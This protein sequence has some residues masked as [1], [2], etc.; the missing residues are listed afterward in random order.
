MLN[1]FLKKL[2]ILLKS[3]LEIKIQK[4]NIFRIQEDNS[5]MCGYFFIGFINFMLA[6]KKLTDYINLSSPYDFK[7]N[8]SII[9]PYFKSE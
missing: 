2:K 9:L 1:I 8:D 7:K 5:I 6:G 4:T 3:S